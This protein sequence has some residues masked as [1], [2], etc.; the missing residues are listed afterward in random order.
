MQSPALDLHTH[1]TYSDGWEIES[2]VESASEVGLDGIGLTDHCPVVSD[3][4]GRRDRYDFC[5]TYPKRRQ[6]IEEI[7]N[8]TAISVFD[9][10]EVNYDPRSHETIST[11]LEEAEFSY[12][13]GSI[14]YV[15][16]FYIAHPSLSSASAGKK[17][18][19]VDRYIEWQQRL[20]SSE[21]FDIV[22]HLDLPQ[23]S[24]SLRGIIEEAD[25]RILA[26][27]L[28]NSKTIPELNAGRIDDQHGEY[29][30]PIEMIE[31][32]TDYGIEFVYGSDSHSPT[33]LEARYSETQERLQTGELRSDLF[34]DV[35]TLKAIVD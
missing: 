12:T 33:D 25:Y 1:T 26:E 20:I 18:E 32:F 8:S 2:L 29:H 19:A 23:R 35:T 22:A 15:D 16:D 7:N 31:V 17:R 4:F 28:S 21:C 14:H 24:P 3:P 34:V 27:A 10:A 9:G 5:E 13:I 30:P 11:F 6:I